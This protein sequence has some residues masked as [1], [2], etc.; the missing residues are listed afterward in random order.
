[1]NENGVMQAA[2]AED[3]FAAFVAVDWGDREHSWALQAA[4]SHKRET[5]TFAQT[6]KAIEE[7]V[8]CLAARFDELPIAIALEQSRGAL[9]CGLMRYR[10]LTIYP[11]PPAASDRSDSQSPFCGDGGFRAADTAPS[12]LSATLW[13]CRRPF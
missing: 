3:N 6:P 4:G 10:H 8:A 12:P 5:G 1:M 2:E 7:W 9:V 11:I 13:W